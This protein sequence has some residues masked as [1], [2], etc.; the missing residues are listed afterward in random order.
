MKLNEEIIF[1]KKRRIG[2]PIDSNR[3]AACRL[4]SA[5]HDCDITSSSSEESSS[6]MQDVDVEMIKKAFEDPFKSLL[7]R[8]RNKKC[9]VW[10]QCNGADKSFQ[11]RSKA[12]FLTGYPVR[13]T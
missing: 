9:G 1:L 3:L 4:G 12:I 7:E 6:S 5:H 8:L 13:F 10:E 11:D 2:V